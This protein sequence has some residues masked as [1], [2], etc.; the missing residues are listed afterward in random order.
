[1]VRNHE[2]IDDT[3]KQFIENIQGKNSGLFG[4]NTTWEMERTK[5]ES[6][7]RISE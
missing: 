6:N 5:T 7:E 1:M 4:Y 3:V 2:K